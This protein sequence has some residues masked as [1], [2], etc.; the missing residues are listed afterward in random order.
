MVRE[1]LDRETQ[2]AKKGLG[3]QISRTNY[4]FVVFGK[5]PSAPRP[6]MFCGSFRSGRIKPLTRVDL[7]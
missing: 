4:D 3:S 1:L 2:S 6:S 7:G 5:R